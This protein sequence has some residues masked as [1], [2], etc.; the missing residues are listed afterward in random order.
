MRPTKYVS[1]EERVKARREQKK[2]YNNKVRGKAEDNNEDKNNKNNNNL[3][4]KT[5]DNNLEL[6]YAE[7]CEQYEELVEH[8]KVNEDYIR[9]LE[10]ELRE[11]TEQEW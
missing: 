1:E 11:L 2:K 4:T 10:K 6:A 3:R 9:K 8:N 7:L 5:E